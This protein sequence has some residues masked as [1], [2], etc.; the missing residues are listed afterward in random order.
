LNVLSH[1]SE[2]RCLALLFVHIFIVEIDILFFSL[3][4]KPIRYAQLLYDG[5]PLRL[6]GDSGATARAF[7]AVQNDVYKMVVMMQSQKSQWNSPSPF[8]AAQFSSVNYFS[9]SFIFLL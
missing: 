7:L 2:V 9:S 5:C 6:G 1:I 8:G 4:E 3:V